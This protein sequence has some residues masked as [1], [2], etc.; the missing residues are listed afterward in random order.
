MFGVSYCQVSA[1][2]FYFCHGKTGLCAVLQCVCI[3]QGML[4]TCMLR[5]LGECCN[6]E[7]QEKVLAGILCIS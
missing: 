1:F 3:L 6:D 4:T 7:S 5:K 2:A